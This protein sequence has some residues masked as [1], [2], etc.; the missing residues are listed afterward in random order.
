MEQKLLGNDPADVAFPSDDRICFENLL[1]TYRKPAFRWSLL[2]EHIRPIRLQV[3][4]FR[5]AQKKGFKDL[6]FGKVWNS[7]FLLAR[8]QELTESEKL[9]LQAC[10]SM[11][12]QEY[13]Y[14][15]KYHYNQNGAMY[16]SLSHQNYVILKCFLSPATT[17]H[18]HKGQPP[19]IF[20]G[21]LERSDGETI[22]QE[23]NL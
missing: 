16:I 10:T 6:Y 18:C 4:Y 23:V 1:R 3:L 8:K 2:S 17:L 12:T 7:T 14:I 15:G 20:R 19:P 11:K 22:F 5:G 13:K 21:R 9:T